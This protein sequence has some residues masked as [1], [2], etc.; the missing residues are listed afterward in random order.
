MGRLSGKT[1]GYAMAASHCTLAKAMA[2]LKELV[3]EGAAVIPILSTQASTVSTRFGTPEE[4]IDAATR[5]TGRRPLLTIPEVEPLGPSRALDALVI[6]PCTGNTLARL[7]HAINDSPVTMSAKTTWRNGR[8]VVLAITT[9]DGLGLNAINLGL[10][11]AAKNVFFVPFGQDNPVEKPNSLDADLS[12]L[13]D[14]VVLA[15]EGRQLQPVLVPR[16]RGA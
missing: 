7:A 10:L 6:C 13:V 14:T 2:P 1:L 4:W 3:D 8:P 5:I 9:N 15:L 16:S 11:L 12:L